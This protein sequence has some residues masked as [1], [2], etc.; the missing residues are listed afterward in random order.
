MSANPPVSNCPEGHA[1]HSVLGAAARNDRRLFDSLNEGVWERDLNSGEVW[2]S[3]RYKALLG[4]DDHE[5]PNLID[6]VRARLHPDDLAGVRQAFAQAAQTLGSGE[7]LA[8]VRTKDGVYRWFRGRFTVWPDA[9]GKAAVLVGALCDVHEHVLGTEALKA[10][11]AVLEQ[12]VSERTQGLEA[13]LRLAEARR[14]EAER[15]N[16]TQASFLAHMS[17]ELR[18]PLNGVLGMTQLA[19]AFALGAEQ[20]RYLELAQQSGQ[21]LLGFLDDALDF[22]RAEAGRLQLHDKAFDHPRDEHHHHGNQCRH[23][24][25]FAC[26]LLA[27]FCAF[28]AWASEINKR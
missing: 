9:R 26:G 12:H 3:P 15:A 21:T 5:L 20:R 25:E 11:Q 28:R 22:A 14:L 2:Y 19:H 4:F 23:Q 16:Q 7:A 24:N 17:H 27:H 18:T 1:P 8:R 10:Q 13:A 6:A